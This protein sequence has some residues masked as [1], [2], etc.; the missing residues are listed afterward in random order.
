[1]F[2][3]I[4]QNTF[5]KKHISILNKIYVG[6]IATLLT[7]VPVFATLISQPV[8]NAAG[9]TTQQAAQFPDPNAQPGDEFGYAVA[10]SADGNTAV[11]GSP[12]KTD[13]HGNTIAGIAYVFSNVSGSWTEVAQLNPTDSA[14]NNLFGFSLSMNTDGTSIIVGAANYNNATSPSGNAYIYTAPAGGWLAGYNS[15]SNTAVNTNQIVELTGSDLIKGSQFGSSVGFSSDG[16]TA[17]VGATF[18]GTNGEAYV[19]VKPAG[20]WASGT[21]SQNAILVADNTNTSFGSS[22]GASMNGSTIVVGAPK[23]PS[24]TNVTGSAYVF[25]KPLGG[26]SGVTSYTSKLNNQTD[27]NAGDN[28]GSS[29]AITDAGTTVAVGSPF[30]GKNFL[31]Q[32]SAIT[33]SNSGGIWTQGSEIYAP[34][35][36]TSDLSGYSVDISPNGSTLLIGAPNHQIA[37]NVQAGVSYAYSNNND[38]TWSSIDEL[39]PN[40]NSPGLNFGWSVFIV[41]NST[42]AVIGAPDLGGAAGVSVPALSKGSSLLTN[43][44]SLNTTAGIIPSGS[45]YSFNLSPLSPTISNLSSSN[46]GIGDHVVITGTN[47]LSATVKFNNINATIINPSTSTSLTVVVPTGATSGNVIVTNTN[48]SANSS[49]T[50][51]ANAP[52]IYSF[53]PTSASPGSAVILSGVRLSGAS[54]TLNGVLIKLSNNYSTSIKFKVPLN[55][56]SGYILISNSGGKGGTQTILNVLTPSNLTLSNTTAYAGT[57]VTIHGFNLLGINNI[58]YQGTTVNIVAKS[59]LAIKV[60]VPNVAH[61]TTGPFVLSNTRTDPTVTYNTPLFTVK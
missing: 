11:V 29:V 46:T 28:F 1:M 20:G 8:A 45:A 26:W 17:I 42:A 39:A 61:G 12:D 15:N 53:T 30:Q 27:P 36:A 9:T 50:V 34:D 5:L 47:L 52:L 56:I 41:N 35:A 44:F 24:G 6:S 14:S 16:T 10:V 55:V 25:S 23:S 13:S 49:F 2:A 43:Q 59:N 4:K 40:P 48:G 7:I 31:N 58:V 54:V 18:S 3:V 33:F 19:F 21:I 38:G 51:N 37:S 57:Y 60:I 22:V 32:G